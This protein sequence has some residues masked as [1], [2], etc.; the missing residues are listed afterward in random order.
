MKTMKDIVVGDE[1]IC[2]MIVGLA[3]SLGRRADG[4]QYR[5]VPPRTQRAR[6]WDLT[7]F[8]GTVTANDVDTKILRMGTV[9]INS[10][11]RPI[12]TS[13]VLMADIHWSSL[14]R[15]LLISPE[16]FEPREEN[17]SGGIEARP[18]TAALGTNFKPF[19]TIE[20]IIILP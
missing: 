6:S 5:F 19:H 18:T 10:W 20:N 2:Y 11:R 9:G 7:R 1:I 8:M 16:A 14:G 13:P 17:R 3:L 4:R 15:V 12:S